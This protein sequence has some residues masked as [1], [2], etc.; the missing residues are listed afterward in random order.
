[1]KRSFLN[2]LLYPFLPQ[3]AALLATL[4]CLA[5]GCK[6]TQPEEAATITATAAIPPAASSALLKKFD[7]GSGAVAEGYDQVLPG[8]AYTA[9][10]GYG[11]I[12]KSPLEAIS[13][14][15]KDALKS[16]FITSSAPFYFTVD[17]PE[18]NYE[19]TVLLGDAEGTSKTTVKAESRRLM[20]E[21]VQTPAGKVEAH[22]FVVNVRTPKINEQESIRLKS[23]EVNY[24]NWDDKL[25]LEFNN[26][27]PAVAAIEIREVE[28]I[29]TVYLAGNSTV[30]DQEYEPWAAWGQMVPRFFKPGVVV[31]NYAE[32]GETLKAFVGEKR[33]EKVLSV[34]K[35]NDYLFIEFAHNDQ[36]PGSSHVDPFTTYKEMLKHFIAEARERGAIPVLVTSMHRRNF[37]GAGKIVNTLGDYPEA[38]RQTAQ[39][40]NVAVIDLNAMSKQFYEAM[41]PENSK[42]AFVHYPANTFPGQDK[43]L[44]DNTHF[45]TYGAYQLARGIVEGIKSNN[46]KLAAY[47]REDV[48]PF[49]PAHP[50][51]F[52]NWALPQS[53]DVTAVKPDGN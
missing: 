33:L 30:V 7:F 37:D 6:T 16:D 28:D 49:D 40:E 9:A 14:K 48:R 26:D 43:A 19:V 51:A 29:I 52:A 36:K 21:D 24:L 15:G 32:S 4:C 1:M 5:A 35:P 12:S 17:L 27:R 8:T 46:L 22:T 13:R 3:K 2:F 53:P 11:L 23:R 25:T 41:G 18:G 20:L 45:S 38:V 50:D 44:E 34:I 31:A 39:E 10:R 47:L 42:K